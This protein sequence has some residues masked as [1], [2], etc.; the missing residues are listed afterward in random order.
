MMLAEYLSALR[1]QIAALREMLAQTAIPDAQ[2]QEIAA[3]LDRMLEIV[4]Q[5]E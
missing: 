1:T 5:Y 2:R 3:K 4:A